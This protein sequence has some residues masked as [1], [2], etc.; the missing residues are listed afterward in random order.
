[1]KTFGNAAFLQCL[2]RILIAGIAN[3]YGRDIGG[4]VTRTRLN[5]LHPVLLDV[6][7]PFLIE[8]QGQVRDIHQIEKFLIVRGPELGLPGQDVF[9][10]MLKKIAA[11]C[12]WSLVV[13]HV[14]IVIGSI[15]FQQSFDDRLSSVLHFI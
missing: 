12:D 8:L 6:S 2:P 14:D 15:A 1:M 10:R 7:S 3:E 11:C 4:H 9:F 5:A 13:K